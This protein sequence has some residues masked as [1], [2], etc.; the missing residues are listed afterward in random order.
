MQH[1]ALER[2]QDIL[3]F[4]AVKR[5]SDWLEKITL[6]LCSV[7]VFIMFVIVMVQIFSRMFCS[8][9]SWTEEL[10]R[11]LLVWIGLLAASIALKQG[12]HAGIEFFVERLSDELQTHIRVICAVIMLIF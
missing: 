2:P 4:R 8:S 9:V 12:G 7:L 11:F 3:A 6:H 1:A 5:V 10:S